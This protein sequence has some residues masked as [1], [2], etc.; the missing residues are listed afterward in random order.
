MQKEING[1]NA[2]E[3]SAEGKDASK[4]LRSDRMGTTPV[5]KLLVAMSLPAIFSMFVQAC[6]NIM[7]T[8]FVGMYYGGISE[9]EYNAATQA[10]SVAFPIQLIVVAL[11]VGIGVG[12]NAV[13]SKKLGEGNVEGANLTAKLAVFLGLCASV[14]M[15]IVGLTASGAF[16]SALAAQGEGGS[17]KVVEY[18]TQYLTIVA[19]LSGASMIEIICGRLFQATGNMRVPMISQLLGA[20]LNIALDPLFLF[21]FDMGVSGV[22]I[23]TVISQFCAMI[24]SLL[25]FVFTKQD[26]SISPK[27]FRF[28]GKTIKEIVN[29]GM[30][31]FVTNAI[32]A[33]TYITLLSIMKAYGSDDVHQTVIS[34]TVLGLYFRLNSLVFMPTFGLVQGALPILGYNYGS[35]NRARYMACLKYMLLFSLCFTGIGLILFETAPEFL[36]GMF[37]ATEEVATAGALALRLI[38]IAFLP[39]SFGITT[40]NAFQ[41]LQC[42]VSA[43][44]M[45]TFRQLGI[46][47][48]FAAIFGMFGV[49]MIWLSYPVAEIVAD[50]VF[51]PI[52]FFRLKKKLPKEK[53]NAE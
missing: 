31:A 22:A 49:H 26:V 15:A 42:G 32:G 12:A 19:S 17:E 45:S 13:V 51:C 4:K 39:A 47:I 33:V 2:E 3:A 6:Y 21:A 37:S 7:D 40:I 5:L 53:I 30:P 18:G 36:L 16:I 14:V 48:P 28:D 10:L 8:V 27:G 52:L 44:L 35:R 20:G 1:N 41:S 24:F 50:L 34:Q 25:M 11:G 38:A 43:L 29:V 23:A 9:I 46:I